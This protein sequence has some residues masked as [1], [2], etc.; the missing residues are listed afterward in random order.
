MALH[1]RASKR[2]ASSG[3]D[4]EFAPRLARFRDRSHFARIMP[5]NG[6]KK[7]LSTPGFAIA[8]VSTNQKKSRE[9]STVAR[10]PDEKPQR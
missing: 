7:E 1:H 3:F 8:S 2:A 6:K 10:S 9:I 5:R 4:F